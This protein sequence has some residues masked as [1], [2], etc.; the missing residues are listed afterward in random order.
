M[1]NT[2]MMFFAIDNFYDDPYKVRDFALNCEYQEPQT[3]K[4]YAFGNAPWPGKM[5]KV[6]YQ[7][8]YIDMKVSKLLNRVVSQQKGN[9]SGKFRISKLDEPYRNVVH[10]DDIYREPSMYAGVVYLNPPEQS[11]DQPGT[12]LY[13]HIPS[14]ERILKSKE[15]L[16]R[17]VSSGEDQDLKYWKP[18]LMSY[19]TWN[20]LIVYP[21]HYFHGT[22]PLFGTTDQD[23]RLVQLFFWESLN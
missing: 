2:D 3:S 20:R 9:D 12:I 7:P 21:A 13:K 5:S 1:I 17:I 15:E 11:N 8:P 23:A 19:V 18:E 6:D 10:A 16:R 14:G 22:G 4:G